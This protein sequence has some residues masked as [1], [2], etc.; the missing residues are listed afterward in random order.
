LTR[1][2][3]ALILVILLA[4][5][6]T[7]GGS[8]APSTSTTTSTTSSTTT[9]LPPTTTTLPPTTTTTRPAPV[10]A[11]PPPVPR[12]TAC[13]PEIVALIEKH[14]SRFGPDVVQWAIGIAWRESN[15]R[16]DVV[17]PGQ[18]FSVLQLAL[19]LHAGFYAAAGYPDWYAVRF[20]AEANIAAAALLYASAGSSP[21]RL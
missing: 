10:T 19:P 15:C 13:P 1:H 9:S 17:S 8:P 14:W 18:C 6:T 5:C 3:W 16:P 2:S 11:P 7:A 4:A 21:W 20:D 12:A